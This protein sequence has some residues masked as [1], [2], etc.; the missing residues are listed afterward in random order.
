MFDAKM[1]LFPVCFET[2]DGHTWATLIP[3]YTNGGAENKILDIFRGKVR[4][5]LAFAD[6]GSDGE[7][8]ARLYPNPQEIDTME[9]CNLAALMVYPA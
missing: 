5:C 8:A 6:D 7:T 9:V 3:A 4:R 1:K 2:E